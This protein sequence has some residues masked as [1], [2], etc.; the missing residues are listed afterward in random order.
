MKGWK[1]E[2]YRHYL[3]A[4]GI[5][6]SY[7]SKKNNNK[8]KLS[9]YEERM[10]EWEDS[11]YDP[12]VHKRLEAETIMNAIGEQ[13]VDSY[14]PGPASYRKELRKYQNS[15]LGP[16]EKD[17]FKKHKA[18]KKAAKKRLEETSLK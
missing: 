9:T 11:G 3:A 16:E 5:K 12:I 4:K 8:L 2:S 1:N 10:K 6:T 18:A 7:Y 15:L 14:N 17:A 13:Q